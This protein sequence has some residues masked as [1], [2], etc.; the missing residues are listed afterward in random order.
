MTKQALHILSF[1]LWFVLFML[2]ARVMAFS[3]LHSFGFSTLVNRLDFFLQ[4]ARFDT[5]VFCFWF[6]PIFVLKIDHQLLR[7]FR[8][9]VM[10]VYV[11]LSLYWMTTVIAL[12]LIFVH[13][14]GRRMA[15]QDFEKVFQW[16]SWPGMLVFCKIIL[17]IMFGLFLYQRVKILILQEDFKNF[18]FIL[19]LLLL[20]IL[21]ARGTVGAHHLRREHCEI[22][23]SRAV[24]EMCLNPVWNYTKPL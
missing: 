3:E 2:A 20:L 8:Q 14:A 18:R 16:L 10:L 6:L 17:L 9:W 4:G 23:E 15:W 1:F 11:R 19:P 7:H 24:N 21:G 22:F 12:D 5:A 13:Q